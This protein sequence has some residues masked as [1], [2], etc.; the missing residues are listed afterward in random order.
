M[1][2]ITIGVEALGFLEI[3]LA[4]LAVVFTREAWDLEGVGEVRG[5]EEPGIS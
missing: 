4:V 3:G 5:F 1:K 2:T